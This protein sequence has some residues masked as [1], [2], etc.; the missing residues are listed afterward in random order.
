M[1]TEK[2]DTRDVVLR[3]G[4]HRDVRIQRVP[5]NYLKFMVRNTTQQ[6]RE[7]EAEMERR[8]T[9]TPQIEI[10]GH[11]ID[12][13]SLRIRWAW[14]EHSDASQGLHS[15]LVQAAWAAYNARQSKS[16]Q[17]CVYLDVVWC[18]GIDGG[19]PILKTVKPVKGRRR[20]NRPAASL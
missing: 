2:I 19:W 14:H 11:A 17:E 9:V 18:F 20:G 3:F 6:W 4:K 1:K 8:G 5:V 13:A 7:A 12:T 10:S 15:W 16:D